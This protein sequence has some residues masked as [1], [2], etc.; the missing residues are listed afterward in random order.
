MS[1][2]HRN[3]RLRVRKKLAQDQPKGTRRGPDGKIG[4]S[5]GALES[6]GTA[7]GFEA[8]AAHDLKGALVQT[9]AIG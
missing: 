2:S 1:S 8:K 4:Q 7:C 9:G 6:A 5:R 3:A